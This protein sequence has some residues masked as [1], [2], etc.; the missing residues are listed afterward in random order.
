M[1]PRPSIVLFVPAALLVV[2][3][4]H[5]TRWGET[6]ARDPAASKHTITQDRRGHQR[7]R[8]QRCH[9]SEEG[10]LCPACA[11]KQARAR[12]SRTAHTDP[13]PPK[14][15]TLQKPGA[16]PLGCPLPKHDPAHVHERRRA[17]PLVASAAYCASAFVR[18]QQLVKLELSAEH[19]PHVCST[20][21]AAQQQEAAS[22]SSRPLPTHSASD[23]LQRPPPS[24]DG[25]LSER[26]PHADGKA[27]VR[28]TSER[29]G[30]KSELPERNEARSTVVVRLP[31]VKLGQ[32]PAQLGQP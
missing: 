20:T 16:V 28:T 12:S 9:R 2:A 26:P 4:G 11:S 3:A 17:F 1:L 30:W 23:G 15:D 14:H 27:G 13:P 18:P 21:R 7:L 10:R 31:E 5:L 32:E 29:A 6:D 25:A 19:T 8:R 22:I 24:T